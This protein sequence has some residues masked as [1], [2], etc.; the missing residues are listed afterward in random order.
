MAHR[1]SE[2]VDDNKVPSGYDK[3]GRVSYHTE[4]ALTCEVNTR[5]KWWRTSEEPPSFLGL[6]TTL[7]PL[8]D[9]EDLRDKARTLKA[10]AA[11]IDGIGCNEVS[12]LPK[13]AL[14]SPAD[15]LRMAETFATFGE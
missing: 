2:L 10:G 14:Q 15:L 6:Q 3:E 13:E 4:D 8:L 7:P 9:W 1:V 12:L 11:N 5:R